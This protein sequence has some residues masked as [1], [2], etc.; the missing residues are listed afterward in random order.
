MYSREDQGP[1]HGK[2]EARQLGGVSV[3]YIKSPESRDRSLRAKNT[4]RLSLPLMAKYGKIL[5]DGSVDKRQSFLIKNK[6]DI[7][8][9]EIFSPNISHIIP[10]ECLK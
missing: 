10:T 2:Y 9:T 4:T 5:I 6:V 7:I 8:I 3:A 1:L